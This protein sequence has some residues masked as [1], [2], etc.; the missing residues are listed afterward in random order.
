MPG[1]RWPIPAADRWAIIAHVRELQRQR[2]PRR[3]E[4]PSERGGEK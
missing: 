1:Y 2:P 3:R 4:G